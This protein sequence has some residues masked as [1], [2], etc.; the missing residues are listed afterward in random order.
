MANTPFMNLTLP[1]VSETLGVQWA[2]LLNAAIEHI[3]AHDHTPGKGKRIP[4]S[5]LNINSNLSFNNRAATSLSYL[6]LAPSPTELSGLPL[7][8]SVFSHQGNLYYVNSAGSPVQVTSGNTLADIP[9]S[10]NSI[11]VVEINSNLEIAP[12]DS[13]AAVNVDCSSGEIIITLPLA[14]SVSPGRIYIISDIKGFC[15]QFNIT[16]NCQA[17]DTISSTEETYLLDSQFESIW[18]ISNGVSNWTLA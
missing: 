17:E 4:A 9:G 8:N 12:I 3:D 5:G 1:V 18:L 14:A 16:V 10:I 7:I 6:Q 13:F 2:T 11:N 15:N